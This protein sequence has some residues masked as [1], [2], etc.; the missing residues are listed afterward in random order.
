MKVLVVDLKEVNS[1]GVV[2]C[3]LCVTKLAKESNK[4]TLYHHKSSEL[5]SVHAVDKVRDPNLYSKV[6][7]HK[8]GAILD[9]EYFVNDYG[10]IYVKDIKVIKESPY[11]YDV[12]YK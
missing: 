3:W 11:S 1:N 4:G 6:C 9:I 8:P 5:L 7:V 10:R 12:L 2:T